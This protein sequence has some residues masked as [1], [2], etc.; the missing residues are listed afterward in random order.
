[1]KNI[2]I[3]I[4]GSTLDKAGKKQSR[5]QRW[6][7][8]LSLFQQDDL[9][10][11][12]LDLLIHPRDD[13]YVDILC[14]DIHQVSP[15][16]TVRLHPFL[17]EQP[18]D[19]E[20]VYTGLYDFTQQYPFNTEHENYLIHIS[21]GTHVAQICLFLL[22][23][24]RFFPARLIQSS[25][26]MSEPRSQGQYQIIDLNL[27][28]YDMIAARHSNR[29][30]EGQELLKSGIATHNQS[31]NRLIS[32]IETVAIKSREPII[33]NGPTGAGKS[34][35]VSSIFQLKR[36]RQGLSGQFIE[37]NCAT[38]QGDGA[39]SALFGHLKG[40]YTGAQQARIGFLKSADQGLLFLDEIAELGLDE[41]A[42][43]L[44]AIE[45]K[46]FTPMGSD[47]D[48][49]SDFQLVVG[50][51]KDLRNQVSQGLFRHDLLARIN[52]WSYRLP[53]L[54]ER[55]EDIAPNLDYELA[56]FQKLNQQSASFSDS[57]K[58]K[59]LEFA[60]HPT[61]SWQGNFRD[62]NSS[63]KRMATLCTNGIIRNSDVSTEIKRLKHHWSQDHTNDHSQ[64]ILGRLFSTEEL[65][66]IDHFDRAQL[67]QIIVVCRQSASLAEAGRYLFQA[68]R[69]KKSK[70]NDSHRLRQYLT[71]F[72]LSW[73][74][75]KKDAESHDST[76]D[77]T[78]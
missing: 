44:R 60:H 10:I 6:R 51:N 48:T 17:V 28:K 14:D 31:F 34:Q 21:T 78:H 32:E 12:R 29:A 72:N 42:M 18:W 71:K 38:I 43:L 15:K 73:Q 35:L 33:L 62:L 7:P 67:S 39:M 24:T 76:T 25:P 56:R 23:E 47:T 37:V 20:Q 59:Y 46:R 57:A 68:S 54:A 16:T 27:D 75:I 5:W 45:E 4:F 26:S 36:Q 9:N 2:I 64:K 69:E 55:R 11:D 70:P 61:S 52:C 49:K 1:M 8:T 40:A 58:K 53:G 13:R 50:T 30:L 63:I 19:F 41:Q 66:Q 3:G 22:T 65:N 77:I 74:M